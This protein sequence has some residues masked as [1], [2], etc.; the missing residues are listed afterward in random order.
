MAIKSIRDLDIQRKKV[1]F[2]F[3][4]NVPL[5]SSGSIKDDT[6][7]QRG[8]PTIIYAIERGARS[9]LTSHLGRPKGEK[10]PELSLRP[11]AARLSQLL[12]RTVGFVNDCIG[13][14]VQ[15]AV[16]SLGDGDVLLLENLRFHPGETKNDPEFA[17]KLASLAEVYINDAFGTAHRAHA[18]T[19]GVAWLLEE[20]GAGLLLKQELDS[21]HKALSNP[22]RPVVAI[23]GGAKVSDKLSVLTNLVDRMDSLLIGGGMANTFLHAKG[24]DMGR[25]QIE[26]EMTDTA[27]QILQGGTERQCAIALPSDVVVAAEMKDGVEYRTVDVSRVPQGEMALDIGARTIDDFKNVIQTAGTIVWNGPMGVFEIEAFKRGTMEIARAVAASPGFSVVGGGDSVR[28]VHQAGVSD[29]ISYISTGGGA[30]IEYME[31]KILPG[32]AAL[33]V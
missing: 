11:V 25:S 19:V 7:I 4:F 9:I 13:E 28:A 1:L 27:V 21:L 3:D 16:D 31:G 20:K 15:N 22:T 33:D 29:Q 12:G 26:G 17:R 30:F 18:S 23:F 32:V 8:L 5:D 10:R 2:R 24:F 6:R 14:E